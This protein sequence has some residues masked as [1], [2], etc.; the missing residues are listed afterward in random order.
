M[1][2]YDLDKHTRRIFPRIWQTVE[3]M[4]LADVL[5]SALSETNDNLEEAETDINQ[6][7]G[8]SIQRL[9]LENSLNDKF[10]STQRRIT[11]TNSSNAASNYIYNESETIGSDL[12]MYLFNESESIP[13]GANERY[14]FNESE[15]AGVSLVPFTVTA[16]LVLESTEKEIAAWVEF[17]QMS[18]TVY[19]L[20]FI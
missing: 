17:V 15:S 2:K 4:S 1:G 7:I 3:N 14:L 8:Y 20:I 10:D 13:S 18:G 5:V 6:R 11:V 9:S 19:E 12:E 16:P